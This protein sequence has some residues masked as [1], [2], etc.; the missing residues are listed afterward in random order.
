VVSHRESRGEFG[1]SNLARKTC[2]LCRETYVGQKQSKFCS[3]E[4]YVKSRRRGAM[5]T[6]KNIHC[7]VRFPTATGEL[8][9]CSWEC[10][11]RDLP[12]RLL[13][14][15]SERQV[16]LD[17]LDKH[18][19]LTEQ[20]VEVLRDALRRGGIGAS[21]E[22]LFVK[23]ILTVLAR[24]E[25][26]VKYGTGVTANSVGV[27]LGL[28][29]G[30]RAVKVVPVLE[31]LESE[32]TFLIQVPDVFPARWMLTEDGRRKVVGNG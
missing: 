26:T 12:R 8:G 23:R 5:S 27:S 2:Q 10:Y 3:K 28:R 29:F 1:S 31:R 14:V 20:E 30:E 19:N 7:R 24:L 16:Y 25:E 18:G 32:T 22:E 21:S 9:F 4:C 6:C 13:L 17:Q 11:K 15:D